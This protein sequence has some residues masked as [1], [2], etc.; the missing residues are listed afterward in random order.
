MKAIRLPIILLLA[1]LT[2]AGTETLAQDPVES[3]I[4]P[5]YKKKKYKKVMVIAP[6]DPPTYR[7]RFENALT[8]G[9]K[10]RRIKAFPSIEMITN[11]QLKDT[12]NVIAMIKASDVDGIVVLRYLGANSK[13]TEQLDFTGPVYIYGFAFANFDLETR[14]TTAG[15]IQ[16]DFFLPAEGIQY[17]SGVIVNMTNNSQTI[18]DEFRI[19]ATRK[20]TGDQ[21][22]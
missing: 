10:E 8:E 16:I 14:E 9:L 21:I 18:T 17:R 19:K 2:M 3:Y 11:D 6:F 5:G 22:L 20:L 12:A 13:V 1:L 15:L 4:K 7:K